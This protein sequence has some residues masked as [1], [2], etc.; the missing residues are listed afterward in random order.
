LNKRISH[1]YVGHLRTLGVE[2][3]HLRDWEKLISM[4]YEYAQD[5][6]EVRAAAMQIEGSEK[7]AGNKAAGARGLI[8]TSACSLPNRASWIKK[9]AEPARL[10]QPCRGRKGVVQDGFC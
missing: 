2:A 1:A 6:Y 4:R 10:R 8:A 5:K 7:R 3:H 9:P